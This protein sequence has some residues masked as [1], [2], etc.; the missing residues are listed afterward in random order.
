M[1]ETNPRPDEQDNSY[2]LRALPDPEICRTNPIG[3][4]GSFA[5]CLVDFPV[6]CQYAMSYGKAY[7]CRHPNWQK[8]VKL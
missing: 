1:P 4:I 5:T 6:T 7:L 2:Y 3:E 8:F